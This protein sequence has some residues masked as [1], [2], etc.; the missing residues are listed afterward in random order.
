MW[1]H[2]RWHHELALE[3][4]IRRR[5]PPK[6]R[7]K[8]RDPHKN[9]QSNDERGILIR[10]A[11]A[12]TS[13]GSSSEWPKQRRARD[14]H[15]NGQSNDERGILIRMA[16]ATTS[17]GS[18]S[19]WPNATTSEGSS[20]EWPKQ[21]RARD[22]HQNGQSNDERGILIR[23]AKATTSEGSSSEWPKQRRTSDLSRAAGKAQRRTPRQRLAGRYSLL[24]RR[25]NDHLPRYSRE[26]TDSTLDFA[27][28]TSITLLYTARLALQYPAS[29]RRPLA[30]RSATRVVISGA[31][32][33][34]RVQKSP[35]T[36]NRTYD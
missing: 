20:S 15:Q 30:Q 21:R 16:K 34:V 7:G 28:V 9:G 18:S 35:G 24:S 22:P 10:M 29:R 17:E 1:H 33:R 32:G 36:R 13:E 12:T 5:R 25:S 23:M 6:P 3:A 11:K 31:C 26:K 14:P 8:A 2:R 27:P 4:R 19:E